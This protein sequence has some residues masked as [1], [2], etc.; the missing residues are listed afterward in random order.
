MTSTYQTTTLTAALRNLLNDIDTANGYRTDIG[1]F[2]SVG[3]RDPNLNELPCCILTP[4]QEIPDPA[5]GPNGY[6]QIAYTVSGFVNRRDTTVHTDTNEPCAEYA[7]IDA[8]IADIRD[9]I[10]GKVCELNAVSSNLQYQGAVR[11]WH[12][13]GGEACGAEVRYLITTQIIDYIPGQ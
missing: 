8:I 7:I 10:E 13:S 3:M 2:I 5:A 1:G 6:V 11:H 12:E 4:A 9:A